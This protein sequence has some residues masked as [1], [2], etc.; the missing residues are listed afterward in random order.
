MNFQTIATFILFIN[1]IISITIISLER[2]KPEKAIAWLLV[3]TLLP[4]VG[5]I[6]Y[7]FLGRNWKLH[8]LNETIT[9]DIKELIYPI[10]KDYKHQEY[11]PLMELLANNSDSPIFI[12]NDIKIFTDGTE[13][14]ASLKEELL[15]ATHHIHLEYYIVKSDDIGNEIK[16]ILIKKSREGVL[17]RFIIDRVG[18][19][20]IKKSYINDLKNAGVDVVQYS[21]F[22]APILRSINT[23]INYRNHRKIVVIDGKVG[24]IGGANIGDE[25]LGKGK[26]GYWRDTHI[27]VKGDFVLGLQA[28]FLDDFMTIQRANNQYSFYDLEFKHYF[29]TPEKHGDKVMQL[30]KSGPDSTFPSIMQ[31]VVKMISMATHHI[32]IT[33]PYFVPTESVLEALRIAAL[34]GIDVRILF[35]G[36]ADHLV[37]YYASRTYLLDLLKCGAHIYLYDEKSFVHAKVTTVDGRIATL[38]TANMDI[39]SYEL[40]YEINAMI[41]DSKVTE[42]LEMMFYNDISK[43]KKLTLEDFQNTKRI[44]K[45]I[46]AVSRM[47][48]AIL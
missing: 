16:D 7:I 15:K 1:I 44:Y 42:D 48:S 23:Q 5:L 11:V 25:Y 9:D 35:P 6:L 10:T 13:K 45:I 41:Y 34:G 46:E 8:K 22:L 39:R 17:V 20:K 31:G 4:P 47:F 30:V 32:Y 27:M 37:V 12:N 14:F 38:G 33:T 36:Q 40:N 24:F 26:L 21:Y 28:V 43:S 3:L 19:I 2:K 18:S 29:P